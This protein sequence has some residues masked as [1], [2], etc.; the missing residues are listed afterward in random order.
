MNHNSDQQVKPIIGNKDIEILPPLP[1]LTPGSL[2]FEP[3]PAAKINQL[4]TSDLYESHLQDIYTSLASNVT[5]NEK[6]NALIYFESIIDNS[7]ISNSL[8]NSAF[9]PLLVKLLK[10][11]KSPLIKQRLCSVIGLLVRHSTVIDNELAESEVCSALIEVMEDKNDKVRRRAIAALGEYMFYAATQLDEENYDPAWDLSD[12]AIELI[13]KCLRTTDQ[14]DIVRF[15]ACK[16][17]ENI[18]A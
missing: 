10:T 2:Q 1:S 11:V 5:V 7:T 16:T 8:I 15:Y 4:I 9:V 14:D 12:Q 13:V 18:C 3:W 17:L 6:L